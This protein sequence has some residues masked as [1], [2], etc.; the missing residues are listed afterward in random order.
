MAEKR[1]KLLEQEVAEKDIKLDPQEILAKIRRGLKFGRKNALL[2]MPCTHPE[3][4]YVHRVNFQASYTCLK[5]LVF[6]S[7]NYMAG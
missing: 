2:E 3:T 6:V 7:N 1:K 4:H 5:Y